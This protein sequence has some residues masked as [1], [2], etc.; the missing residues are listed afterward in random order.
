ME[1][2]TRFGLAL[3]SVPIAVVISGVVIGLIGRWIVG[4]RGG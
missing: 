2:M 3:V 4:R 1:D